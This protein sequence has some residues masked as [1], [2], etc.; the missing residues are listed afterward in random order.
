MATIRTAIQIQDGM[1]PAFKSMNNALNIVLS[2]F[3][4][5]QRASS[6]AIDTHSIQAARAELNKAE[7]AF[8]QIEQEIREADQ[9][10]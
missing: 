9:A 5:L 10:Q 3:E 4:S 6:K 8:N 7:I 2:S 1:S